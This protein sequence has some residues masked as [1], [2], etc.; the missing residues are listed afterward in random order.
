MSERGVGVK[1]LAAEISAGAETV[2][3]R[4]VVTS[5]LKAVK[6]DRGPKLESTAVRVQTASGPRETRGLR[7][8][9]RFYPQ[10]RR[11]ITS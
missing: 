11:I 3:P 5:D 7:Q 8:D 4:R 9:C 6:G 10:K 1:F 2:V